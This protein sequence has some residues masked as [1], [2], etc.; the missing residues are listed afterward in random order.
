M[1]RTVRPLGAVVEQ[2]VGSS[3]G[4][5]SRLQMLA[6]LWPTVVEGPLHRHCR[7][8]GIRGSILEIFAASDAAAQEFKLLKESI[9]GRIRNLPG[10]G[11]IRSIRF[12]FGENLTAPSRS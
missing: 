12:A 11:N 3:I 8:H 9:V 7:P 5:H 2:L 4:R 10:L 6:D 1:P